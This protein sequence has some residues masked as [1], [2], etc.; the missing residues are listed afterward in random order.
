MLFELLCFFQALLI[1]IPA[2]TS[3][4]SGVISAEADGSAFIPGLSNFGTYERL[5]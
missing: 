3:S 4:E 1:D 5:G 2:A